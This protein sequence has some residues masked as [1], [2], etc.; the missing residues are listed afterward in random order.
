MV[1]YGNLA[2]KYHR[3][4]ISQTFQFIETVSFAFDKLPCNFTPDFLNNPIFLTNFHF[5]W[6]FKKT[7]LCSSRKY[8]YSPYGTFFFVLHPPP[9]PSGNSSLFSYSG[10]KNL[11]FKTPL[12]LGISNDLPWSEYGFFL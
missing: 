11:V 9:L 4:P 12:P 1:L 6:M 2:L 10:F 8:P 3:I 7:G 5:P